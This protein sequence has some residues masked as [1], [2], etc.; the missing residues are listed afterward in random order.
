MT[1]QY[2]NLIQYAFEQ[3][4]LMMYMHFFQILNTGVIRKI[5]PSQPLRAKEV[6]V[7]FFKHKLKPLIK[8]WGRVVSQLIQMRIEVAKLSVHNTMNDIKS[9][10]LESKDSGGSLFHRQSISQKKREKAHWAKIYKGGLRKLGHPADCNLENRNSQAKIRD[11][12]WKERGH[13]KSSTT[14]KM[15]QKWLPSK[16]Q[17]VWTITKNIV[18]DSFGVQMHN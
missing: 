10:P 6:G 16:I 15:L 7:F 1:K 8:T 5:I 18:P 4:L 9:F 12:K 13:C 11:N 3:T 17:L 14:W 2:P